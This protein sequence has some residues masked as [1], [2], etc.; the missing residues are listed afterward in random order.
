MIRA[1]CDYEGVM[2][3]SMVDR[4]QGTM[5][6]ASNARFL[7]TVMIGHRSMRPKEACLLIVLLSCHALLCYYHASVP[8]F[9]PTRV[10]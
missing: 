9:H 6:A 7:T 3:V 1:C 8:S 10:S 2:R 5:L 4:V